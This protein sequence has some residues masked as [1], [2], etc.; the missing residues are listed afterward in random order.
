M[1]AIS[2]RELWAAIGAA[3]QRTG[4]ASTDDIAAELNAPAGPVDRTWLHLRLATWTAADLLIL[5]GSRRWALT[6]R[7]LDQHERLRRERLTDPQVWA[8]IAAEQ[9]HRR[10]HGGLD[11]DAVGRRLAVPAPWL[12]VWADEAVHAGLLA[13]TDGGL[14][15]SAD[16][17]RR[18]DDVVELPGPEGDGVARAGRAG[19]NGRGR[20]PG[21][22]RSPDVPRR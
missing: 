8:A 21:P 13:R 17:W 19:R 22:G 10:P 4:Q 14:L 15:P 1:A 3:W 20:A 9:P 5:T 11:L 7:G 12:D 6:S 16:G 18:V 2:R